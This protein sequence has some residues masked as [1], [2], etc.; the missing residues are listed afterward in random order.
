MIYQL[1]IGANN[2]TGVVEK[3]KIHEVLNEYFDGYT[4]EDCVGYWKGKPEQSVKVIIANGDNETV[5]TCTKV[6]CRVL[7]Q[8]AVG[9]TKLDTTMDFI[10]QA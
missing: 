2:T 3:D 6:L 8:D 1:S 10:T 4:V 5:L 9:L 7:D